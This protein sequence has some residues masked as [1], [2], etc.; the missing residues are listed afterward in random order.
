[1]DGRGM[2][3]LHT[4][5]VGAGRWRSGKRGGVTCG[6]CRWFAAV[7]SDLTGVKYGSSVGECR[8]YAPRGPIHF[9]GIKNTLLTSLFAVVPPDDWCGEFERKETVTP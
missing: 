3:G 6:E 4:S 9:V 2:P 8:R 5:G 7:T 1:V